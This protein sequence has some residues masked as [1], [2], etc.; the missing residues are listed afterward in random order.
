[1]AVT[2]EPLLRVEE[3]S[4][5]YGGVTALDGVSF[6]VGAG[7]IVG[8]IGPNGAGKTTCIDAVTGFVAPTRGRCWFDGTPTDGEPPH[9]LARRGFARTFQSLELFDDLTVRENLLVSASTPTW[10]STITDAFWPKR[11]ASAATDEVLDRLRLVDL[12]DRPTADLSNGQRHLV[13]VGRALVARPKLVLLDEPAAGLDTA[14][15]AELG[16]LLRG[17]PDLGVTVLLV[18]HDMPLVLGVCDEV[19]VLDFGRLIAGG[20]PAEVRA[21]PAVVAAYLG[22]PATGSERTP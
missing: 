1:M 20:T 21:D 12:A 22:Q 10:R 13:A 7:T 11:H 4:V 2:T 3:L 19:L 18:D 5:R 16:R 9:A 14:E 8:L 6:T 15:T 17:L